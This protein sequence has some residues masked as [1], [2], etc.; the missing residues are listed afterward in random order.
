MWWFHFKFPA[1]MFESFSTST[2]LPTLMIS[3][4]SFN[5]SNRWVIVSHCGFNLYFSNDV[6]HPFICLSSVYLLWWNVFSNFLPFFLF[7]FLCWVWEFFIYS[8]YKSFIRYM[9]FKYLSLPVFLSESFKKV[10]NFDEI[11]FI[12]FCS[13]GSCFWYHI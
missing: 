6:E 1:A 4:F 8:G 10:L 5:H 2:S 9:T 13:D 3:L 7:V 12:I 11:Q